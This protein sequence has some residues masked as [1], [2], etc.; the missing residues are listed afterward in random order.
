MF[1][2]NCTPRRSLR[3]SI[4]TSEKLR[5]FVRNKVFAPKPKTKAPNNQTK[6]SIVKRKLKNAPSKQTW[7]HFLSA[8]FAKKATA[9]IRLTDS[10]TKTAKCRVQMPFYTCFLQEIKKKYYDFVSKS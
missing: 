4:A 9:F 7:V 5:N 10:R 3:I 6:A 1:W 2:S 8:R